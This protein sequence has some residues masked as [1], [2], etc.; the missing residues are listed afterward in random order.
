MCAFAIQYVKSPDDAEEVV[1]DLFVK[2]WQDR[3]RVNISTSI[4]A[5]LFTAVRN[6]CLNALGKS[7]RN[8]ALNEGMMVSDH[9]EVDEDEIKLRNAKVHAA[10]EELPEMRRKVFKLSRFEGLKYKEI[11]ERLDISI[12]TVE[13]QMGSALKTLRSELADIMP[14]LA[15]LSVVWW[16]IKN[17][18]NG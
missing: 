7:K 2:L 16:W 18:G 10:I 4:K 9:D 1:Q 13:N 8:E 12:K 6:R 11:A 14:L 3:E 17:N 15:L 5:Y